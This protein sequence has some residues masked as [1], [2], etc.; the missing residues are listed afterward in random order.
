LHDPD[1]LVLSRQAARKFFGVDAPIG[2]TL[3]VQEVHGE[4]SMS[5]APHPMVV[6]AV[7]KDIP[8]ATHLEQFKIY[9]SGRAPWSW[10]TRQEQHSAPLRTIETYVRLAPGRPVDR[11]LAGFP[12]FAARHYAEHMDWRFRLEPLK[13]MHLTPETR[14]VDVSIAAVG[15]LIVVVAAIN[16]VTLMTAYATRRAVEIGVR[17]VAGARRSQL[18]SQFLGETLIQMLLAVAIS[19]AIVELALPGVNAFLRRTIAF[20]WFDD[21]ALAAAILGAALLTALIAGLY[22]ALVLS[23]FRPAFALRGAKGVQ[24]GGSGR[25]RQGLVVVQFA[26]LMCLT[27]VG[28]TIWRQT[29]FAMDNLKRMKVDQL[30][31][32]ADCERPFKQEMAKL[33]GVSGVSCVS[34]PAA[35][36]FPFKTYVNDPGR[37]TIGISAAAADVGFFEMHGLK[38]LAGRFFSNDHGEDMVLDRP[39]AGPESQPSIV[40]NESAVRQLGFKSPQDAVGSSLSWKRAPASS[41]SADVA[42]FRSSRIV[43]VVGDFTLWSMRHRT[44]PTIY[45]A[46]PAEGILFAKLQKQTMSETLGAIEGLYRRIG[47]V[48]PLRWE[49]LGDHRREETEVRDEEAQGAIVGGCAG[50]A[51]V[52]AGLGLFAMAAFTAERRT[53]EIGV[54]KAMGADT[55]Q[56]VLPLLWQFTRPVLWANLVAW[57][58][59]FWAA[60]HWLSGF[61]YRVSL[62]PWLFLTASTV[63]VLIALATVGGQA[64]LA[65][66]AKPAAALRYE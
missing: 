31:Y 4:D 66:R 46:D 25:V 33:P 42:P 34:E 39:G 9:A 57:P 21:P 38:P 59:S 44:E 56:A 3:L 64:W 37:G 28:A 35:D 55:V 5:T 61:A 40:L 54:R 14:A 58:L 43:G 10:Q 20:D 16:F 18:M 50:L 60:D 36:D 47:H 51:I 23:G 63:A 65:A 7:L 62:P 13:D 41:P 11:V 48:R 22:P 24:A 53:K 2:R 15:A 19:V 6:R 8:S 49:V 45:F 27:I 1:G 26:V 17:K 32:F 52:I 29:S 12:A 30:V